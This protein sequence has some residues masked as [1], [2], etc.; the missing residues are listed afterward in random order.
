MR[1]SAIG[2]MLAG[3]LGIAGCS[4]AA[5]TVIIKSTHAAEASPAAAAANSPV[6]HTTAN[7]VQ[8]AWWV[9]DPASPAP[10][11][12]DTADALSAVVGT[13]GNV[14]CGG[15]GV[16]GDTDYEDTGD[17]LQPPSVLTGSGYS[18]VCSIPDANAP[19]DSYEVVGNTQSMAAATAACADGAP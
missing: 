3:V 19:G 1:R 12:L 17:Q 7:E 13:N 8:C 4:S 5:S 18:V 15:N 14:A 6:P 10:G 16:L 2:A 9:K 11:A